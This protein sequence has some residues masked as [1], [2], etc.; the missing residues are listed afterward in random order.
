MRIFNPNGITVS[1][2]P[3]LDDRRGGVGFDAQT[4]C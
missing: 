2:G 4:D 1:L 3:A